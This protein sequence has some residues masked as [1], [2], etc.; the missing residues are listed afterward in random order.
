MSDG[1]AAHVDAVI[2]A[3]NCSALD[4]SSVPV[5]AVIATEGSHG[6][7]DVAALVTVTVAEDAAG[8]ARVP[9]VRLNTYVALSSS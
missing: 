5:G 1:S 6:T 4:L 7:T 3:M 2:A 9:T 8:V